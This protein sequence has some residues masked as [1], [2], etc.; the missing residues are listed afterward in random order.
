[1]RQRRGRFTDRRHALALQADLVELGIL[2]GHARLKSDGGVNFVDNMDFSVSD[3]GQAFRKIGSVDR[4]AGL[5]NR[6]WY[7]LDLAE[8]ITARYVRVDTARG[9]EWVFMD[10]IL[11]NGKLPEPNLCHAALGKPVKQVSAPQ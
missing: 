9:N 5:K 6:G 2:D 3:D 10:E 4:P 8:P 7:K 1:M 11:V